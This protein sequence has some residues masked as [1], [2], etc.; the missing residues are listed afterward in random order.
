MAEVLH[1]LS[2]IS[3][4]LAAVFVMLAI[5]LWFTLKI[6]NVIGD[7]SGRNARKSIEQMRQNNEKT[8]NKS[9]RPSQKNLARGKLTETMKARRQTDNW[10]ETGILSENAAQK[11]DARA[12]ELLA[13]EEETEILTGTLET[14]AMEGESAKN[15]EP[16]SVVIKVLEEIIL[17]HTEEIL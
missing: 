10:Q 17:V 8:G 12:T 7:L 1:T 2:T 6:P 4:I 9:Y 5:V 15:R 3:F 16:S 14:E 11:Y 13:D